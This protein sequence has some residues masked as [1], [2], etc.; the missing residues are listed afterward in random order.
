LPCVFSRAPY[1]TRVLFPSLSPQDAGDLLQEEFDDIWDKAPKFPDVDE[2]SQDRIDVDSF[3]QVYRD[4]D[5]LFEEEDEEVVEEE[6]S[7]ASAV[8]KQSDKGTSSSSSS[9]TL[10]SVV[11]E[12][13]EEGEDED[14]D[15]GEDD[16][17]EAELESIFESICDKNMLISKDTLMSWDEVSKLLD[18]GLL[19]ED[20][21]E[22]L[23][24]QTKK[25][26]GSDDQLDVDG[27]LSFN[28]ALDALFDFDDEDED[29]NSDLDTDEDLG[30]VADQSAM[31]SGD[32]KYS[33]TDGMVE[34]DNLSSSALF[35]ALSNSSG[36]LTQEGLMKWTELK[37]MLEDGDLLESELD[38]MFKKL[39]GDGKKLT[40][41]EFQNLFKAIDDMFEDEEEEEDLVGTKVSSDEDSAAQL[42]E[43]L[44]DT[45]KQL[46]DPDLLPYGLDCDD[47]DQRIILGI[48]ADLE[49]QPTNMIRS[50]GGN[51]DTAALVGTWDLLYSSSSAM[52]YNKGLSGLGGSIPNAKTAGVKQT[53]SSSK[54]MSDVEYI[55]HIEV[56][57][58]SASFDVKITGDWELRSSTS[59][60][61]GEPTL[62]LTITPGLV[63]YGPTSTKADHWKSIGPLNM[64]DISYL[65]E[66]LR[67]MRGNT[68]VDNIFIFRRTS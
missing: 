38:S 6:D 43:E 2:S 48:V 54:F 35:D 42:K 14:D 25:S 66:D 5:D 36:T 13:S 22:D 58:S 18:D 55:E 21:L 19:G 64:L 52:K 37:E 45:L 49:R 1:L 51:I 3:V 56:N 68:A 31:L 57:P 16:N 60:F 4:I 41:G 10:K 12:D 30:V 28:V 50:S 15:D 65:D 67:I 62:T 39:S 11:S 20:E 27:F 24:K 33:S 46:D 40:E 29:E 26:P 34:G 17:M 32:E 8:P 9:N 44:L 47:R 53:L 23:W 61:T 59:L 63:V 7:N